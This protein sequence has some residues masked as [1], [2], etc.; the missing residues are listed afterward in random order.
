[1][2]IQEKIS[3]A[4]E[5]RDQLQ[6]ERNKMHERWMAKMRSTEIYK[7]LTSSIAYYE[8]KIEDLKRE[9]YS[10]FRVYTTGERSR[11]SRLDC[12]CVQEGVLQNVLNIYNF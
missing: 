8:T 7:S 9:L 1:M 10:D 12:R 2:T 11:D 3:A 6:E 4:Q 5:R